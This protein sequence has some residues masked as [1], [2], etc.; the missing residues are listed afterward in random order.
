MKQGTIDT[1]KFMALKSLL[2]LSRYQVIGILEGLWYL[3]SLQA[4]NGAIGKF[5]NLE[6]AGWLEWSGDPDELVDSLIKCRFLDT[7][8]N[9]RLVIHD[10][11][12]HCP[13]YIKGN[14]IRH[15]H[16]FAVPKQPEEEPAKEVAK[17]APK[18]TSN[19]VSDLL[20]IQSNSIQSKDIGQNEFDRFWKSYP[21][22]VAKQDAIKAWKKIKQSEIENILS[23]IAKRKLNGWRGNTK[24]IPNAS[25]YLNGR[26][27]EDELDIHHESELVPGAI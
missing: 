4:Q 8:S 19:T 20:P 27:W 21:K 11:K 5:S 14:M 23:D 26:R 25:T 15:G 16:S 17:D 13:T 18:Q 1:I 2:N 10:W 9:Y 6:I 7:C 3:T 22:K 24:F 12:D